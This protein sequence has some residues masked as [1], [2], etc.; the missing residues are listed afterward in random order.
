MK[1]L[2]K[3]AIVLALFAM[4][5]ALVQVSCSK[6]N[7]QPSSQGLNQLN[8]IIYMKY[9][10]NGGAG[11]IWVAN[12][13]GSNATRFRWHYRLRRQSFTVGHPMH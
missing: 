1:N 2:F 3:G 12:Y 9:L 5:F 4:A 6:S 10:P 13:D 8:K 7:A 11:T